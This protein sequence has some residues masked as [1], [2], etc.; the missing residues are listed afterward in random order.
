MMTD[1]RRQA[2]LSLDVNDLI[3]MIGVAETS[4]ARLIEERDAL[5]ARVK[6]QEFELV[7]YATALHALTVEHVL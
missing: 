6:A 2:L 1:E 7:A 4:V 5:A 3:E